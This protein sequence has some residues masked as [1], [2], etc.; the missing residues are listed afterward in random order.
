MMAKKSSFSGRI[1]DFDLRLLNVFIA[2]VDAGGFTAAEIMLNKSKSAISM[3]ISDLEHRLQATLCRRGRG[4]FL[5]T[6]QGAIVYKAS[7]QLFQD[8][9]KFRN[10]VSSATTRLVGKVTVLASDGVLSLAERQ[11]VGA[12]ARYSRTHPDVSISF[13]AETPPKVERAVLEESADL[14]ISAVP[15]PQETL[16]FV[17]L[18]TEELY[19][20]C[21]RSHP[22][23][24]VANA[25]I[26][27][28]TIKRERM[29]EVDVVEDSRL[30]IISQQFVFSAKAS[31]LETRMLLLLT[32]E[33]LGFLPSHYA[34]DRVRRGDIRALAPE[35]YKTTNVAYLLFK[36]QAPPR[37]AVEELRRT[38]VASFAGVENSQHLDRA[39]QFKSSAQR[40]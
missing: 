33:Y 30:R 2:V 10:Q 4:G 34:E 29:I 32:G 40:G 38:L 23:F 12:L 6:E 11:I 15:R 7:L 37:I 18:V 14:G 9:E 21:S 36:K 13:R 26:T 1:S 24:F 20:Y 28:D 22:L 3:D 31:T 5:L 35:I 17:P 16:G 25:A 27:L 19:L 8:L 39:A